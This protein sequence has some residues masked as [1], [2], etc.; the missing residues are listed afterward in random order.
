M[1]AL[2][3]CPNGIIIVIKARQLVFWLKKTSCLGNIILKTKEDMDM[4]IAV[5]YQ[6]GM[7]FQH[8]GHSEQFKLYD[9]ENGKITDS[10][11]VG[12]NGQ[13]HGALADFL[14]KS[15]VNVLICGGIGAGAQNALAEAGIQLFGG[16]SGMADEAVDAYLAGTLKFNA[17]VCCSHHGHDHGLGHSCGT[18]LCGADKHGCSGNS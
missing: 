4:K 16:V 2:A 13:G 12:T 9:V 18:H 17:D 5:T 10:R 7:I 11:V 6:N 14:A 15:G 8:F 1:P 3:F